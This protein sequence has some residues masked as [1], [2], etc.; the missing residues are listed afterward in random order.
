MWWRSEA[1]TAERR[2]SD[3]HRHRIRRSMKVAPTNA[4][5][6]MQW[7]NLGWA[8]SGARELGVAFPEVEADGDYTVTAYRRGPEE[9][10]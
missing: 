10:A 6:A 9:R 5:L 2:A 8:G 1:A 3:P 4:T 7:V